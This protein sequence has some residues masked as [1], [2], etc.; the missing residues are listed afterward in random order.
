MLSSASL[1]VISIGGL[2]RLFT[3]PSRCPAPTTA[4]TFP[5]PLICWIL[6][7]RK[8]SLSSIRTSPAP[9]A[10]SLASSIIL[11][12]IS[13]SPNIS[14]MESSSSSSSSSRRRVL[15]TLHFSIIP[16]PRQALLR[17]TTTS[18]SIISTGILDSSALCTA[19]R[20]SAP[21]FSPVVSPIFLC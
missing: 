16:I 19:S 5:L 2:L 1:E 18:L 11:L 17:V 7:A 21:G 3:I 9:G 13:E 15:I 4:S 8:A 20:S 14:S 6:P 12:N 10:T